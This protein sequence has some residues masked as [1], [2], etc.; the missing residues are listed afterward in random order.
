MAFVD[1]LIEIA[2][3]V[4]TELINLANPWT[5][6][7]LAIIAILFI[8]AKLASQGLENRLEAR[9]RRIKGHQGLLRV[10]IALMRRTDWIL[11]VILLFIVLTVLRAS[12][13]PSRTV[14]ISLTLSLSLAWL[15]TSVVSRII[16]NRLLA[17][18][19]GWIAW[20]YAAIVIL[21][22]NDEAA[23]FLDTLAL[24]LGKTRLSALVLLKAAVLLTAT[25]WLAIV[26][27]NYFDERVQRSDEL[28]PSIRVLLGKLVKIGLVIAAG[29][30]ALSSVGV[31]LTAL[32]VFSGAIGVG[33]GFGLQKVVSNFISGIIILLDKSIKPGDT[34]TLGDTFGWIRELRARFV[35]V[36]TR[37]GREYLI[38]NE[39]F[40]TQQVI[41]WSFSDEMVRLDVPFGVSYEADPHQVSALAIQAAISVGRVDADRRPVCWL[42]GFGDSSLDFVL[43][44]WIRDPQQGLTNV[45]GKVLL[46]LWDTLKENGIEIPYPHRE[47]IMKQPPTGPARPA[48]GD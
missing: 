33:L 15:F 7:Q 35:S 40:I 44:F 8:V 31:D 1:I 47:V 4:R 46:A 2:N 38:P 20:T 41:N 23:A 45:R 32:T 19:I 17:R 48:T 10:I 18:T 11:F 12:T 26:I 5:F 21:G 29:G 34:I 24:P 3:W 16:R 30:I 25:V 9:A 13:W 36:I 27:G 37:D 43:R 39:D 22:V 42:T 6:Y 14:L 28:T